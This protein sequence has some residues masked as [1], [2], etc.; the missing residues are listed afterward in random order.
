MYYL[1]L[2]NHLLFGGIG[3]LSSSHEAE[4]HSRKYTSAWILCYLF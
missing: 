4:I 1:S 2:I 3:Y